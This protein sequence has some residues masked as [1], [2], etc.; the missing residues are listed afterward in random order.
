MDGLIDGG[1]PAVFEWKIG[2]VTLFVF[3]YFFF[4][5]ILLPK[6]L[7]FTS[8]LSPLIYIWLYN[9]GERKILF[10]Y[11]VIAL[12][13]AVLQLLLVEKIN[14]YY[15]A[16]SFL[17]FLLVYISSYGVYGV[18]KYVNAYRVRLIFYNLIKWNFW[19]SLFALLIKFT[20][21]DYLF[22]TGDW[23]V[24]ERL[25]LLV[26]E[27]SY[28]STLMVPLA[29]FAIYDF[30]FGGGS[31]KFL[32]LVYIFVPIALSQSMGVISSLV[33][34][35]TVTFLIKTKGLI[36]KPRMLVI[37]L[38]SLCIFS[39]VLAA[40]DNSFSIR[41]ASILAGKDSSGTV[42]VVQSNY[43]AWSIV[44][45]T[46][47]FV[48]SGFGQ[49][50]EL[51][52]KYFDEFWL[53]LNVRRMANAISNTLAEFGVFGLLIR[54]GLQL[55]LFFRTK[56][57]SSHFRLTLFIY[58]FIYQFSGSYLTNLPEYVIWILAFN[59]VFR[60]YEST[61]GRVIM[62]KTKHIVRKFPT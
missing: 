40:A 13:V 50:K 47:I 2:H 11:F 39:V 10:R 5:S 56:V 46:S 30:I 41:V 59:P 22:W 7:L 25:Q 60:E 51:A 54:F 6:G 24:S 14:L 16:R 57:Y 15:F 26:Y 23:D 53:G 58:S 35:M 45:D 17:L 28:Y 4:N 33:I 44:N 20:S 38:S 31:Q 55:W 32:N 49:S 19:F 21:F 18:C 27:P 37:I 8:I 34:A 42:R 52:A 62:S 1:R 29:V 48:G 3:I 36:G 61:A 12:P 43:V 9:R